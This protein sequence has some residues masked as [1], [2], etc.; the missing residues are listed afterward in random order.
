VPRLS[1]ELPDGRSFDVDLKSGVLRVGRSPQNELALPSLSL[2][3]QHARFVGEGRDWSVEDAGSRNGSFVNGTLLTETVPLQDGDEIRLGDVKLTYRRD[4]SPS[5]AMTPGGLPRG[6][7]TFFLDRD[8]LDLKKYAEEER[9]RREAS[10]EMPNVWML[11]GEAASALIADYPLDRLFEVTLDLAFKA[12]PAQ[13]A[14]ILL[15]GA[16]GE[17]ETRASRNLSSDQTLGISRTIAQ[18][19]LEQKKAVLTIDAQSDERFE[20]AA[21]LRIQ[22]V[23]SVLCV[24]LLSSDEVRGMLYVDSL[25]GR[26]AFNESDLRLLGL[27]GNMAAVK[28]DN[29]NLVDQQIEK[30]R[31]EEQIEVAQRIQRRLYPQH[32]PEIPGYA[33]HGT[34]QSCYEIGGD[35]FDFLRR[36]D[37]KLGFVVADVSGKGVGAALLMSAFQASLRTLVKGESTPAELMQ[38]VNAVLCENSMPGKFVTV[39]YGELDLE[40]HTL[41]YVNAGHNSPILIGPGG[42]RLLES[43]G[44]V[45]GILPQARFLSRTTSIEPGALLAIYSDGLSEAENPK[46]EEFGLER[47]TALVSRLRDEEPRQAA[48]A[49]LQELV[50]FESTAPRKDDCTLVLV[51][52]LP[53]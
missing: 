8:S 23:R 28:I 11:L 50:A 22:G 33:I 43:T 16:G 12:V 46:D 51:K 9:S 38:R 1:V 2:S 29:L 26:R 4:R 53:S 18:A 15:R 42:E 41:E 13:R 49:M 44:P 6:D 20:A 10:G 48:Q 31:M 30:E 45:T 37:G 21:S 17:L 52:R 34:S 32:S 19:V 24:P 5:V 3:R 14:A 35:Y 39:F 7:Q 27:I 40:S 36:A 25:I 47:L